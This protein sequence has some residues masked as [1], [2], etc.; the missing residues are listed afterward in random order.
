MSRYRAHRSLNRSAILRSGVAAVGLLLGAGSAQAQLRV[1]TY[2]TLDKPFT[3]ADDAQ[4]QAIFGAIADESVNGIARPADIVLLQEQTTFSLT[5]STMQNIADSLNVIHSGAVYEADFIGF[6]NDRLA[7]VYNAA[8]V[9]LLDSRQVGVGIR[10]GYRGHFRPVGYSDPGSDFYAYSV[11]FKAGS[12]SSDFSARASEAINLTNNGDSLGQGTN[13]IYAGDFNIQ[14]GSDAAYQNL[15]APGPGQAVDPTGV[16]SWN[17]LFNPEIMTQSTRTAALGDGG[18]T[19]GLDDRFDF[20]FVTEEVNDG[21]GFAIITPTSTGA[22]ESSYRAFGN[23]GVSFNQ[24]INNTTVGRSQPAV[25]LNALHD[26]SD[27][28]PVVADYQLPALM[29]LGTTTLATQAFVGESAGFLGTVQNV[30]P[31]SVAAGADELDYSA[32]ASGDVDGPGT[33][34]GTAD[35]LASANSHAFAFD[36]ATAGV[37]TASF[38]VTSLSD[39]VADQQTE[40]SI[41]VFDH[42]NGS[43]ASGSD[44]NTLTIDFGTVAQGATDGGTFGGLTEI[45]DLFNL[46]STAGFTSALSISDPTGVAGDTDVLSLFS[47]PSFEDTAEAG[48]SVTRG[49]AFDTG[50][51][52]S[53]SATWEIEVGDAL[54]IAGALTE[55]L[56]LTLLGEVLAAG[57]IDGDYNGDGTV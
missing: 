14:A 3:I 35:P 7:V 43:F 1:V 22:A 25:V 41:S 54:D 52:G 9:D 37:R 45:F 2:N 26:F 28:L 55:T 6:G 23:D 13:I 4:V 20:Q 30:A 17:G 36:T 15:I 46:E 24:A 51:A 34:I 11:H 10:P 48:Q 42:A 33:F 27:H 47:S 44:V 8:T 57:F 49:V 40:V 39:G 53:F 56:T 29:E 32:T 5:T 21:E 50:V 38:D 18:A 16:S 19:S 31:V 12:S